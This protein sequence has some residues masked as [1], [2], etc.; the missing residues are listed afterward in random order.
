MTHSQPLSALPQAQLLQ[1]PAHW[2][3][4]EVLSDVHL[5]ASE[6]ANFAAWQG[7]LQACQADALFILGDLFEVWV[8]DDTLDE[9]DSFES[10]CVAVLRACS[11][12]RP[13]YLMHGNR[14]FLFGQA[15]A[16]HAGV[17]L[18][19]DPT[20]LLWGHTR[21][22]LT[23]GDAL[24][25]DDAP[26]QAFRAQVRQASWQTAFLALPLAQRREMAAQMRAQSASHKQQAKFVDVDL[27][28]AA[29][30]LNA[31]QAST[32]IHGH[33]HQPQHQAWGHYQ[34]HVLSD[35]DAS[36]QKPRLQMMRLS[37]DQDQAI[38]GNTHGNVTNADVLHI[39][40]YT[41]A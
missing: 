5:Q 20:V 28:L 36:T 35:W 17:E 22:L 7:A 12:Q 16:Q 6:P 31:A 23:H 25:I 26:Y 1:A 19:S 13:V 39:S 34:R 38:A 18:L 40:S 37:L 8:G 2:R 9:R 41:L 21:T 11:A 14:D 24:C 15:A 3:S 10:R 30:W 32:L 29:Q 4:I 27:A 33:T